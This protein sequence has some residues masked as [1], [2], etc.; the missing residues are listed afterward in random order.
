VFAQDNYDN[1]WDGTS[2]GNPLPEGPY[3][4]VIKTQNAG[5]IKGTVNLVR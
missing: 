2:N 3:Y 1:L 5:T 4:Y